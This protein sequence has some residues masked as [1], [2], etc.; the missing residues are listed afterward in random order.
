MRQLESLV[1]LTQVGTFCGVLR[2]GISCS[3]P[4]LFAFK[5]R[6][7]LEMRQECTAADALEVIEIMKVSMVDY[8]SDE[9]GELDFSRSL[10]GSGGSKSAMVN[11]SCFYSVKTNNLNFCFHTEGKELRGKFTEGLG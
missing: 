1:R 11:R 3:T 10:N 9:M 2:A 8:Y 7:K 5:A 6:A 4:R